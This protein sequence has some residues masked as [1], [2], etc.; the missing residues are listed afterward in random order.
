MAS[1]VLRVRYAQYS[2]WHDLP[3]T[4]NFSTALDLLFLCCCMSAPVLVVSV[5]VAVLHDEAQG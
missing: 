4:F 3:V 1:V 5:N 2:N